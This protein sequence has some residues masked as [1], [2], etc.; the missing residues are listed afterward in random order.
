MTAIVIK[1]LPDSIDL[2]REAMHAIIGGARTAG[3]YRGPGH[4]ATGAAR[5]VRYPGA[6]PESPSQCRS[7]TAA[8]GSARAEA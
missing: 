2:D 3:T 4:R 1:D 5:L 6:C 8:H 7:R